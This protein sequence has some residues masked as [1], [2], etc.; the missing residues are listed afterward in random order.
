MS[1]PTDTEGF[2]Q[3]HP[4]SLLRR[5]AGNSQIRKQIK[6]GRK[7]YNEDRSALEQWFRHGCAPV[8]QPEFH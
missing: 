6:E 2:E 7:R 4:N 5:A 3:A 8:I 1:R